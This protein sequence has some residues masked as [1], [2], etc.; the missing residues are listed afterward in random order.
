DSFTYSISDGNGGSDTAT[1]NVTVQN[2]NDPPVANG[3]SYT[4]NQDTVLNVA[5]PGV[6][7]NDTDIDGDALT[8]NLVS[9]ASHGNVVLAANGSFT[10]TPAPSFAGSDSF[11][12]RAFD[13]TDN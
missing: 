5:A 4:I 6:L 7:G 8:A 12:Y 10:Y 3:N 9:G 13:G 11:T 2:V 1:V